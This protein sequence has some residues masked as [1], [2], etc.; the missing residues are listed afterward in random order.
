MGGKNAA[1]SVTVARLHISDTEHNIPVWNGKLV[2]KE[3]HVLG[4]PALRTY[5]G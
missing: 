4:A 5:N 3:V 1:K 2:S